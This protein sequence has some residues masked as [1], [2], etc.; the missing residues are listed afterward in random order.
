M[1]VILEQDVPRLGKQGDLVEVN[2]GYARN[3]L[4]PR[5]LAKEATA[6]SLKEVQRQRKVQASKEARAEEEARALAERLSGQ[7]VVITARAGEG[8]RL[9]GSVTN[10][11]IA[12]AIKKQLRVS[13]DKRRIELKE[14]L[15]ALG[16]HSVTVRL[17]TD[18]TGELTVRVVPE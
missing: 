14:P 11:D 7:T 16:E 9:F 2:P 10:Q 4:F 3:Y 8:G 12:D 5:R 1:K 15:K 18:V 17:F 13:I 6:G